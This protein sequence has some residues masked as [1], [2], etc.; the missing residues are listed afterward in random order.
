MTEEQS[1][2]VSLRTVDQVG[3]L[4]TVVQIVSSQPSLTA[5]S[6]FFPVWYAQIDIHLP[7]AD[8]ICATE[9]QHSPIKN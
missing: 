6:L 4:E 1:V 8:F 2:L 5:A 7:I 9:C 3:L